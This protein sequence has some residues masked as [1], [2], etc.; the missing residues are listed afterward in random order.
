MPLEK[1]FV[2]DAPLE[3]V[4]RFLRNEASGEFI[5]V[6]D[7]AEVRVY[8]QRGRLAWAHSSKVRHAFTQYLEDHCKIDHSVILAAV[9]ESRRSGKPIGETLISTGMATLDQ[10][11]EALKSQISGALDALRQITNA[12]TIFVPR[13]ELY[14]K[15]TQVTFDFADIV[16]E[17]IPLEPDA[18]FVAL[19][20]DFMTIPGFVA[21]GVFD[22]G[23]GRLVV[24]R[25]DEFGLDLAETGCDELLSV[26]R[27]PEPGRSGPWQ[28]LV[29]TCGSWVQL[30]QPLHHATA[31]LVVTDNP[32]ERRGIEQRFRVEI[33]KLAF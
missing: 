31:I 32:T 23:L 29:V 22:N 10:V 24:R 6:A 11:R 13:R 26:L 33:A 5:A 7:N 3:M 2:T 28:H 30:L 15:Y 14:E 18:R 19:V 8:L 12:R 1:P 17:I 25:G 21:A 9:E 4:R 16:E 27:T 20:A